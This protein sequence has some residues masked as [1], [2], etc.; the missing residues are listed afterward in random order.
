[1][2]ENLEYNYHI[3]KLEN[4]K[5]ENCNFTQD[6]LLVYS[7]WHYFSNTVILKC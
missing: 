1:M 3:N 7:N 2:S 5:L 6:C 4:L